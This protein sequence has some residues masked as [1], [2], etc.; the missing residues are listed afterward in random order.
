MVKPVKTELRG[1][2]SP[3]RITRDVLRRLVRGEV[4]RA[5]GDPDRGAGPATRHA[6]GEM[7][8]A[9]LLTLLPRLLQLPEYRAVRDAI[10]QDQRPE[11]LRLIDESRRDLLRLQL[12]SRLL[13]SRALWQLAPPDP[14]RQAIPIAPQEFDAVLARLEALHPHLYPTWQQINF[15]RTP[16]EYAA[17]PAGSCSVGERE[18][19]EAFGG[20]IAPYL[21]GAVLD[22]GC[23]PYPVPSYLRDYPTHLLYGIDPLEPFQSHPFSFARGLAESLPF[24]TAAFD[25]VVAATSLDHA[26]SLDLA[27]S[28]AAR[29]VK[30]HGWFLVWDG[31]VKGSPR[32]DPSNETLVPVDEFHLFHFDEGWF[33]EIMR[34][35][36]FLVREKLVFDP[37]PHNP[38][39]CASYFYALHRTDEPHG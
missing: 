26:F 1:R 7:L 2:L 34:E 39:Y 32:Y 19:D 9:E 29:V 28:E 33:E 27:L 14:S 18:A 17:R 25:V 3:I 11:T 12:R 36:H 30:A 5:L 8:P 21:H 31:F 13:L 15:G 38:Q 24:P 35:H 4:E 37:S 20:F 6:L 10:S 23:G 16:A 22:V